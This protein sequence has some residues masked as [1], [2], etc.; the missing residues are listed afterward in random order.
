V[1][2][3]RKNIANLLVSLELPPRIAIF[4]AAERASAQSGVTDMSFLV[5]MLEQP[6][7]SPLVHLFFTFR[8]LFFSDAS[9]K[10]RLVETRN[11]SNIHPRSGWIGWGGKHGKAYRNGIKGDESHCAFKSRK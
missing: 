10:V 3:N 11:A 7:S 2:Q 5:T 4:A 6:Q 9:G 1:S 8:A